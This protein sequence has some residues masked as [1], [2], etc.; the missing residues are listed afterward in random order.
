M[1]KSFKGGLWTEIVLKEHAKLIIIWLCVWRRVC[2]DWVENCI[3]VRVALHFTLYRPKSGSISAESSNRRKIRLIEDNAK[4]L[5]LKNW[6][7]KRLCGRVFS[8]WGPSPPRTLF[9]VVKQFHKFWMWSD[10]ECKTLAE[11]ALQQ[12]PIYPPCTLYTYV[13]MY[14]ILTVFTQGRGRGEL[15]QREGE[16]SNRGEYRLQRCF[17]IPTWLNAQC[18]RKVPLQVYFLDDDILHWL[19][20]AISFYASNPSKLENKYDMSCISFQF[21]L[22]LPHVHKLVISRLRTTACCKSERTKA[23]CAIALQSLFN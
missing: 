14:S 7:V 18:C 17:E 11:Y 5:H 2:L 19:L 3:H 6:H 20:W 21:F 16:M 13:Y 15:N 10:T 9:G 23:L 8:V 22:S 1:Y 4:C 12:N